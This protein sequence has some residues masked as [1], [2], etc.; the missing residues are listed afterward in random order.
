MKTTISVTEATVHLLRE[1]DKA[2]PPGCRVCTFP[3][4]F[5]GPAVG[6]GPGYWYLKMPPPCPDK[7]LLVIVRVWGAFTSEYDIEH[8]PYDTVAHREQRATQ[9]SK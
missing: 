9:G 6:P 3:K 2:R 4:P 5:W 1:F 8:R 7:C